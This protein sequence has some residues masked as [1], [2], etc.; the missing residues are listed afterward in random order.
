MVRPACYSPIDGSA[1]HHNL[2][3][4]TTASPH[5][6]LFNDYGV[7]NTSAY[8]PTHKLPTQ[9]PFS[10]LQPTAFTTP[11]PPFPPGGAAYLLAAHEL[12]P[13]K[14]RALQDDP[15]HDLA[16]QVLAGEVAVADI[17]LRQQPGK[18]AG[19]IWV[20]GPGMST[21]GGQWRCWAWLG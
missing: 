3:R 9:G 5:R 15:A 16:A 12:G 4:P 18:G 21:V 2:C 10:R 7:N 14:V 17:N 8:P 13:R 19:M 6:Q 20:G 1:V 11:S